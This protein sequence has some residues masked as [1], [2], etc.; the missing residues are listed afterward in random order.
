MSLLVSFPDNPVWVVLS[1]FP[2]TAP[3]LMIERFGLADVPVWQ[4][5]ASMGVLALATVAGLLLA[6]K[7]FK[8]YLLMVGKRPSL[9]E[10][11]KTIRQ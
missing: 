3:V 9:R 6:A 2:L 7:V 5:A 4:I 10:I 1:I 11:M 8:S